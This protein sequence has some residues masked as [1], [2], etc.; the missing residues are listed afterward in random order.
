MHHVQ[1][2]VIY[3][4]HKIIKGTVVYNSLLSLA[5]PPADDQ[6]PTKAT[7]PQPAPITRLY[8]KLQLSPA[9]T[10]LPS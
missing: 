3:L 7:K 4:M 6:S 1:Q 8:Q 5:L 2:I 9:C 10:S